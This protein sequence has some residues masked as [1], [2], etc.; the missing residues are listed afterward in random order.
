MRYKTTVLL[1]YVQNID[2]SKILKIYDF[3]TLHK[4]FKAHSHL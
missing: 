1:N 2:I 3:R 4:A